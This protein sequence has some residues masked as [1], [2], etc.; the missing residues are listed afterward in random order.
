MS[1]NHTSWCMSYYDEYEG[2]VGSA[3]RRIREVEDAMDSLRSELTSQ[4][5]I[6]RPLASP[7]AV[8]GSRGGSGGFGREEGAPAPMYALDARRGLIA[9]HAATWGGRA[10]VREVPGV[11]AHVRRGERGRQSPRGRRKEVEL[12]T[13]DDL[14]DRSVLLEAEKGWNESK[15]C[16]KT[17][18]PLHTV[19]A[20]IATSESASVSPPP[21]AHAESARKVW[22]EGLSPARRARVERAVRH[23]IARGWM[24]TGSSGP[25]APPH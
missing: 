19:A 22:L 11:E 21:A 3:H 13:G 7:L 20:D 9:E 25:A 14:S 2:S 23:R 18:F 17:W 12:R 6:P 8:S 15:Q 16:E 5:A 1:T 10:T 4:R 24:G